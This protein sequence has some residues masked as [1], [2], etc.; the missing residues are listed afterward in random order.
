[1]KP[2]NPLERLIVSCALGLFAIA[3]VF[4]CKG[5][6]SKAHAEPLP[7]PTELGSYTNGPGQTVVGIVKPGTLF[8]VLGKYHD[9]RIHSVN[10][11]VSPEP[12]YVVIFDPP[13]KA[14]ADFR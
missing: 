14:E 8:D 7:P 12:G 9:R 5:A 6:T 13:V 3:F 11:I 1:M 2:L 4:L 10:V